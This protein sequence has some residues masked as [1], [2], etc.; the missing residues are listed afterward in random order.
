MWIWTVWA[1]DKC[2]VFSRLQCLIVHIE[3]AGSERSRSSWSCIYTA[4]SHFPLHFLSDRLHSSDLNQPHCCSWRSS[5][6]LKTENMTP[7][8][9]LPVS[10]TAS[11]K[12]P[13]CPRFILK[14]L[15]YVRQ[16]VEPAVS[17]N[18]RF[19]KTSVFV[20][21]FVFPLALKRNAL[22]LKSKELFK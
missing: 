7:P 4:T 5:D 11:Q 18:F 13:S 6:W 21:W 3:S 10:H 20:S 22:H 8:A 9:L 14:Y 12:S 1:A 19:L 17:L 16:R 2:S 15:W